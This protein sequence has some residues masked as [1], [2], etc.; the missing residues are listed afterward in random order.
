MPQPSAPGNENGMANQMKMMNY[1]MPLYS[2]FIVFF[3][4]IG[5]GIYWI[6]GSLI[7][8]LQQFVLNKHFDRMDLDKVLKE[9]EEKAK[10]KMKKKIEKKGVSG[11]TIANAAK[12]NARSIEQPRRTMAQ[13]A[14]SVPKNTCSDNS[15]KSKKKDNNTTGNKK[16]YK[17]GSLSSKANLVRDYNERNTK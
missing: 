15:G 17:E 14:A 16:K 10:E 7:R 11:E 8:S 12:I 2:F 3:L 5:V 13:K 9:N 6:A 4:P 1:F